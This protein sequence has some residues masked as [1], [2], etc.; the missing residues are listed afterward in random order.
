MLK[1]EFSLIL[2][3]EPDEDQSDRL[4]AKFQD[5]T[6]CTT[7]GIP[8]IDFHREA[9]SLVDAIRSAIQ[10]TGSVGCEVARIE[11]EPN[12]VVAATS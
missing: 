4:Y 3:G 12:A 5:G 1:H 8:R 6:I 9:E 11:I 10:D 2:K 7:T